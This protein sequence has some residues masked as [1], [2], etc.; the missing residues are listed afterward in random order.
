MIKIVM[1]MVVG[2]GICFGYYIEFVFKGFVEVGGKFMIICFIEIFFFCG[3]ECIIFGMGY[4]KEVYEVFQVDF[5]QIEICFSFCYVDINSMYILYNMCDVIGDDNFLLFELDFVFECKVIFLLLDD[6]FLD[7]MFVFFLIKFQDQ[8]Y[9]EYD[10]NYI[11]IFCLVDKNV[12]EVKGELVGIYKFFNIFYCWMCVDYV[13]ILEFQ[14][15]LGY[16]YELF[17]MFCFVFFVCVFRVE[18]FKWYEIDDEVDFLYV[19]EYII[20]YC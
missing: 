5:F 18:G 15:K 1:I 7:V 6:E 14:F 9:V 2:F 20:C 12:F 13:I 11:F 16:E 19:E 10:C 3:I 4:K 8:Y 17:C